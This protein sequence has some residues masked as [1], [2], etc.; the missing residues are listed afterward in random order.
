M[1]KYFKLAITTPKPE[2]FSSLYQHSSWEKIAKGYKRFRKQQIGTKMYKNL[3]REERDYINEM[4]EV[5]ASIFMVGVA[6]G[7]FRIGINTDFL[8]QDQIS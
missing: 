8:S 5:H 6:Y 3:V 1:Y 7:F 2:E 4:A